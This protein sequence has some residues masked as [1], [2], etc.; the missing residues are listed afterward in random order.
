MLNTYL[1]LRGRQSPWLSST[2]AITFYWRDKICQS[3]N[4]RAKIL[5]GSVQGKKDLFLV[6]LLPSI[7]PRGAEVI[8]P[9]LVVIIWK[10]FPQE[11]V[12]SHSSKLPD[13]KYSS[14]VHSVCL[15]KYP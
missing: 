8:F 15:L 14:V 5:R 1:I 9:S 11:D 6:F 12:A 13:P 2:Q 4:E 10:L 7:S 3:I